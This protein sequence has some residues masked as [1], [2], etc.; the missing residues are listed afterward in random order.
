MNRKFHIILV[1]FLFSVQLYGQ[2]TGS[3]DFIWGNGFFYN[4]DIG[5]SI[6]F[7]GLEIKIMEVENHYTKLKVGADTLW[8]KVAR[9]SVPEKI[10][11]VRVYVA[12]NK[13]A[14]ALSSGSCGK[15]LLKKDVL[16]C[17]SDSYKQLLDPEKFTFPVS[18]ND[19]FSW[20]AEEESYMFSYYNRDKTGRK[21]DYHVS[22]GI[23]FDLQDARGQMKHW[24]VAPEN[25]RVVWIRNNGNTKNQA[26]VLL[27]SE[28][29]PGIYY[30]FSKLFPKNVSVKK[31][32]K[33][34]RGDAVGTAW[35]DEEW[36]YAH[37]QVIYSET[38][39]E[40]DDCMQNSVNCFP[41][42]FG[43]YFRQAENISRS[44]SR[45]K[46]TFGRLRQQNG[47]QKNIMAFEPYSGKGWILSRWCVAD[48][49]EWVTSGGEGNARLKKVMFEGTPAECENPVNF[50]D[51]RITVPNGTYRIRAKVGDVYLPSWQKVEFEG[52]AS[53]T[54]SLDAGE[55]YWTGERIVEVKDGSLDV[56]IY[57][58]AENKKVAGLSEIV[59]QRAY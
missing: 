42:L 36:G 14:G 12:D 1:L 25:S 31:G 54:K 27:E 50:F 47:N 38:E 11:A 39:P 43:L 34:L 26:S 24:L 28:S 21:K 4:L 41:Q 49:V 57:I 2:Q 32:Q 20:Q 29:Q 37:F 23:G 9:R 45:G 55:T 59:F 48:K 30:Y 22:E 5:E 51:Y 17:L 7:G 8:L 6:T 18:F 3:A 33:L 58:D 52:V 16:L 40:Y 35:G 13:N 53:V 44:F 56:R 15:R 10:G 46:I 19:G